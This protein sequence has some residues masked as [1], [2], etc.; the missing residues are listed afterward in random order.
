MHTTSMQ[1]RCRREVL[2][3]KDTD[4]FDPALDFNE[5]TRRA[6]FQVSIQQPQHSSTL[7]THSLPCPCSIDRSSSLIE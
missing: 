3:Q 2:Q 5:R 4:T 7:R 1:I 6:E